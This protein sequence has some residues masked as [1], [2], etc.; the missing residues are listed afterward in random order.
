MYIKNTPDWG[1]TL[2]GVASIVAASG[3]SAQ[4]MTI[5]IS[6]KIQYFSSQ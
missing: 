2:E 3:F 6:K 4:G 1:C 5:L